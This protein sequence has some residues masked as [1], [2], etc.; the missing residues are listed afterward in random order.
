MNFSDDTENDAPRCDASANELKVDVVSALT[1]GSRL[2]LLRES[3][4]M[5]QEDVSEGSV[6]QDGRIVRRIEVG[7]VESGR[8][9]ASTRRIR[10]GLARAFGTSEDELFEYL[11]GRLPL[12]EYAKLRNR[13]RRP[14][15]RGDARKS[16]RE[17]A[18][19]VV[20]A[21]GYGSA[22]EV[23]QAA[24]K[25]RESLPLEK[26]P[27]LGILEWANLIETTLRQLR[28]AGDPTAS[29]GVNPKARAD[30]PEAG[31]LKGRRTA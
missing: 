18:I 13:A 31:K 6:D 7:H 28:R 26:Q 16:P 29:S 12:T 14:V 30:R 25:A 27:A 15:A 4:D 17:Q 22:Q 10:A 11:E 23:R 20:I 2:R 24:A 19:E 1:L 5:T 8:N 21:D 3:L 9:M